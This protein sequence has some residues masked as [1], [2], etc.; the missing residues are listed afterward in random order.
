MRGSIKR[1]FDAGYGFIAVYGE[2]DRFFHRASLVEGAFDN[3]RPGQA[4][5]FEAVDSPRGLRCAS[6]RVVAD[7]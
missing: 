2:A 3:L 5:E 7:E 1:V 6:V 4:V